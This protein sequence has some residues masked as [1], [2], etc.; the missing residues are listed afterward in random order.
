MAELQRL[1]WEGVVDTGVSSQPQID[2][3]EGN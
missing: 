1:D 2:R 3:A